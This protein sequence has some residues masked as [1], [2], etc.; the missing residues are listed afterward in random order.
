MRLSICG[1]GR[2]KTASRISRKPAGTSTG[3]S[4][5]VSEAA[6]QQQIRLALSRAGSVMHRNNIGAYRDDQGR[7]IRYGVGN[8]GGSDLIGW[9]PVL[10]T[11]EMVG[12]MLGVFTAIEVKAPRGRPT[13]AQLNFL[14][15]VQLGGG[16]AGIARST[17]D[18]LALLTRPK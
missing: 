4:R 9:T 7:V 16:I 17:Q 13:E 14:R 12:G 8:P 15:Q 6:I 1:V 10:I 5:N 11:H 2:T 18:A 3:S